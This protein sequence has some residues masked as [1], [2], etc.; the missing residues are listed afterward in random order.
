MDISNTTVEGF[1]SQEQIDLLNLVDSLRENGA[2]QFIDLP[3]LIVCGDTSSGK[4]SLLSRLSGVKFPSGGDICTKFAIQLVMRH[5]KTSSARA[6]IRK[7]LSFHTENGFDRPIPRLDSIAELLADAEKEM[8]LEHSKTITTDTFVMELRGPDLPHLTLVDLPGFAEGSANVQ[9]KNNA[10]YLVESHM[11]NPRSIILEIIAASNHV[12]N[13]GVLAL[14]KKHDPTGQR[15]IGIITKPDEMPQSFQD[16]ILSLVT[17]R[18]SD[19]KA[20]S[21]HIVRNPTDNERNSPSFDADKCEA[22][23][24]C[25]APWQDLQQT[26]LG[27]QALKSKLSEALE[28]QIR[29]ELPKVVEDLQAKIQESKV[30]LSQL[31]APRITPAEQRLYLTRISREYESLLR[32][33][34]SG[35]YDGHPFFEIEHSKLRTKIRDHVDK[36]EDA[37]RLYGHRYEIEGENKSPRKLFTGVR[38]LSKFDMLKKVD[39]VLTEKRGRE[40]PGMFDPILVGDLFREQSSN[41]KKLALDFAEDV[42]SMTESFLIHLLHHICAQDGRTVDSLF[43]DIFEEELRQR[44]ISV[45]AKIEEIL[46]PYTLSHPFATRTRFQASLTEIEARDRLLETEDLPK[47]QLS[48]LT[49]ASACLQLLKSSRAY[50]NVALENFI[51]NTVTLAVENCILAN[52][53]ALFSAETV[54]KMN[55]EELRRLG[56]ET[57]DASQNRRS[58]QAR[59]DVLERSLETCRKVQSKAST[60]SAKPRRGSLLMSAIDNFKWQPEK[61]SF[62]SVSAPSD[63]TNAKISPLPS[64]RRSPSPAFPTPSSQGTKLFGNESSTLVGTSTPSRDPF[65]PRSNLLHTSPGS[66]STLEAV[67]T[68]DRGSLGLPGQSVSGTASTNSKTPYSSSSQPIF[69]AAS[70]VTGGLSFGQPASAQLGATT[71]SG[72]GSLAPPLQSFSKA[73]TS[74]STS[75]PT[76][77]L[78]GSSLASNV[79]SS[80]TSTSPHSSPYFG[81][82]TTVKLDQVSK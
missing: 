62:V 64:P 32:S 35:Q 57:S 6:T 27:V 18:N 30:T 20:D 68:N 2:D 7:G 46:T 16:Q 82:S 69:G 43:N 38:I 77:N 37:M 72:F 49:D 28:K 29:S 33:A 65:S 51:D 39:A 12:S 9:N 10:K 58:V 15:T 19:F 31:G 1:R 54:S 41:W 79:K 52:L 48:Q 60:Y 47:D 81:S 71:Q 70:T 78:F 40:L 17:K 74:A 25:K 34:L 76:S 50:Y 63:T 73:A 59:L 22:E 42:C 11:R 45:E 80:G 56:S 3:E 4:S 53:P 26:Q 61:N 36:F 14:A 8:G 23:L 55:D 5:S 67:S 13:Q 24:F 21:W 66:A 75:G 44:K